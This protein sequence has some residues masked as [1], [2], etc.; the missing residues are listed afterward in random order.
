[1]SSF[2]VSHGAV[3]LTD[4]Y[5]PITLGDSNLLIYWEQYVLVIARLMTRVWEKLTKNFKQNACSWWGNKKNQIFVIL[6][7]YPFECHEWAMPISE[8]LRQS[9]YFKLAPSV[10]LMRNIKEKFVRIYV[11][12]VKNASLFEKKKANIVQYLT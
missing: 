7:S 1:V 6:A 10:Q 8:A 11:N 2:T 5:M 4:A 12:C 9:P 3:P